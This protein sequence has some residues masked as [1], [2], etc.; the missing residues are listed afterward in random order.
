MKC[1][2][3]LVLTVLLFGIAENIRAK[4]LLVDVGPITGGG[5]FYPVLINLTKTLLKLFGKITI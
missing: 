1:T 3:L 4:Y 5:K 2:H